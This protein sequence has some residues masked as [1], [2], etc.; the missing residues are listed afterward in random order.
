[1]SC[2]RRRRILKLETTPVG[3]LGSALAILGTGWRLRA[4]QGKAADGMCGPVVAA[5][6]C[7]YA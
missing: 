5:V 3:P 4:G 6:G 7:G 2:R 1:M